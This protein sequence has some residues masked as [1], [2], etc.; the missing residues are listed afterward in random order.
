MD[1]EKISIYVPNYVDSILSKDAELFEVFKANKRE[2]NRNRFLSMLIVG[3]YRSYTEECSRRKEQ[4]RQIIDDCMTNIND[5]QK[6]ELCEQINNNLLMPQRPKRK[7]TEYKK[8]SLKPTAMTQTIIDTIYYDLGEYDTLSQYF[9]HMIMSYCAKPFFERERIIFS[10]NY[11]FFKKACENRSLVSFS[12][13]WEPKTIYSVIPYEI[14]TSHEE[15]MNYV[16]C[17]TRS[18]MTNNPI[19]RVFRLSRIKN[20][21]L[22]NK[23]DALSEKVVTRLE[24][25]KKYAPQY[26]INSDD[27]ICVRLTEK[28]EILYNRI[29]YSRPAYERI[30]RRP[31]GAYYFFNCSDKQVLFY[32]QRFGW[33]SAEVISPEYIRSKMIELHKSALE[34][35]DQ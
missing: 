30:E 17:Q 13:I 15:M 6:I 1:S 16:L 23:T 11:E 8:L 25:M 34:V 35:Y 18:P 27:E 20:P 14:A 22:S 12:L 3:Y 31:D 9:C 29:Y 4:L 7:I 2:I 33:G 28:G 32:F 19:A 21:C 10:S 24:R 5:N 26:P